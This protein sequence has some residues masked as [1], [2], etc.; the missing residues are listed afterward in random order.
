[1]YGFYVV[2]HV[3]QHD[4]HMLHLQISNFTYSIMLFM[5]AMV[6]ESA[7]NI[8]I[9][10]HL[11]YTSPSVFCVKSAYCPLVTYFTVYS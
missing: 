2:K 4:N 3:M 8:Y 9:L 11:L 6:M 10:N 7:H 5:V 1:M